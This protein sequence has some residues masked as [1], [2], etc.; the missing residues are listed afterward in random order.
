MKRRSVVY[1]KGDGKGKNDMGEIPESRHWSWRWFEAKNRGYGWAGANL[2]VSS[3]GVY[4]AKNMF[5]SCSAVSK[6]IETEKKTCLNLV[7]DAEQMISV[8]ATDFM[9][10]LKKQCNIYEYMKILLKFLNL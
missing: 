7:T 5:Q 9:N 1:W 8:G 10:A 3:S 4:K 2:I 6:N